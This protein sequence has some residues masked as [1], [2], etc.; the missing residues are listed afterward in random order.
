VY[1]LII[2]NIKFYSVKSTGTLQ[3]MKKIS[4]II[5]ILLANNMKMH[6]FQEK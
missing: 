5:I 2:C 1:L 4:H 3:K 6:L